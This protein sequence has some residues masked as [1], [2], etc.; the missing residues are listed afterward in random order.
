MGTCGQRGTQSR[1]PTHGCPGVVHGK[2]RWRGGFV[3]DFR[4]FGMSS[5]SVGP[6]LFRQP[7]PA[8]ARACAPIAQLL[9][10]LSHAAAS[11]VGSA[12][13]CP[14]SLPLVRHRPRRRRAQASAP[15]CGRRRLVVAAPDASGENVRAASAGSRPR[16]SPVHLLGLEHLVETLRRNP[17]LRRIRYSMRTCAKRSWM[18]SWKCRGSVQPVPGNQKRVLPPAPRGYARLRPWPDPAPPPHAA[19]APACDCGVKWQASR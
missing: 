1:R 15:R 14:S 19:R 11:A 2:R 7:W 10:L 8:A 18:C 5:S 6:P 12:W 3:A 9:W 13:P 16:V 4:G 17:E